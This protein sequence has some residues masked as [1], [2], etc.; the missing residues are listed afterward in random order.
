MRVSNE[1][2]AGNPDGARLVVIIAL[3]I[4]ICTAVLLS[5]TLLS[6]R[7]FVGIAF[8]NEEEV[9]NYVTRMVPLLSISVLTDNLQGV[10]SGTYTNNNVLSV[11][12]LH[13]IN[14]RTT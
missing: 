8:S 14:E 1:L 13:H 10:L 3:S 5:I 11:T 6:L 4:I 9:V 12:Q 7:H 2:G